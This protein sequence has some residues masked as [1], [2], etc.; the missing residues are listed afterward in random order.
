MTIFMYVFKFSKKV[1]TG[2]SEIN[3]YFFVTLVFLPISGILGRF[4]KLRLCS[5]W[6]TTVIL[7]CFE[8]WEKWDEIFDD[9]CERTEPSY[10]SGRDEAP[11]ENGSKGLRCN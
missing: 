11:I 8:K 7:L 3:G 1:F 9:A 10:N 6:Y 5:T 4:G 2:V